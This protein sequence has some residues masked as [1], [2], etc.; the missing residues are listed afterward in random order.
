[1]RAAGFILAGVIV[2][3][4]GFWALTRFATDSDKA[5]T[6]VGERRIAEIAGATFDQR[7]KPLTADV[8][9]LQKKTEN[10]E[11]A[12]ANLDT[13]VGRVEDKVMAGIKDVLERLNK[14][15]NTAPAPTTPSAPAMSALEQQRLATVRAECLPEDQ[16]NLNLSDSLGDEQFK[17]LI[18]HCKANKLA[19]QRVVSPPPAVNGPQV[20]QG[21][22]QAELDEEEDPAQAG[23]PQV[24]QAGYG[25]GRP[26]FGPGFGA[27]HHGARRGGPRCPPGSR[28]EPQ[29]GKCIGTRLHHVPL[30]PE[31]RAA[32]PT[33]QNIE[34][35]EVWKNG[36]LT[37]QQ[38]GIGCRRP[39]GAY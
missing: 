15:P 22:P 1:M 28:F 37:Q 25:Y 18:A 16:Q 4:V 5:V 27:P 3:L 36:R 33:C 35:R 10:L 26:G 38:R 11:N 9:R 29:F 2:L 32:F 23:E 21:D 6:G 14:T 7:I 8:E 12:L 17:A 30:H 34:T 20:A 19:K 24:Q 13:K 31:A 39:P